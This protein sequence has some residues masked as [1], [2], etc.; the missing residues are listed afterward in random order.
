MK[1]WKK[2]EDETKTIE[3]MAANGMN[4]LLAYNKRDWKFN[5]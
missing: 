3:Y 4:L 2:W 1:Q 5:L